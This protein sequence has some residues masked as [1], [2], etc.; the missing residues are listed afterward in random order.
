M[1]RSCTRPPCKR[2][3][4]RLFWP[5][6]MRVFRFRPGGMGKWFGCSLMKFLPNLTGKQFLVKFLQNDRA[7]QLT[8]YSY[9]AY[10]P[11]LAANAS[12]T[13]STAIVLNT[14]PFSSHP[15]LATS[16]PKRV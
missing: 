8:L 13:C 10:R 1:I 9:H 15:R 12:V 3:Y 14:S 7:S 2:V 5:T 11:F 16:T 4:E 6:R